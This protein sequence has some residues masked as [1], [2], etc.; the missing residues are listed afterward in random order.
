MFSPGY[1]YLP[2]SPV[3]I[4]TRD[5]DNQTREGEGEKFQ[6]SKTFFSSL[7][8]Q[9]SRM[10]LVNGRKAVFQHLR[11]AAITNGGY[12]EEPFNGR[13]LKE[14]KD[15]FGTD[16]GARYLAAVDRYLGGVFGGLGDTGK[17]RI[18]HSSHHVLIVSA[19]YGLLK[20]FEP[21]Q[22]CNY[23]QGDTPAAYTLWNRD[24][25][26]T[27]LLA[28]YIRTYEIRRIFDFTAF[29][30]PFLHG[31]FRWERI[32]NLPRIEVLH[33]GHRWGRGGDA[34][35]FFGIFLRDTLLPA[36]PTE[37]LDLDPET[38]YDDIIFRRELQQDDEF[39]KLL[40]R[41]ESAG[42]EFK[43]RALWSL[44]PL[45]PQT[46]RI[47]SPE[48]IR[49]GTDASTF[50]LA[51][52]IAGFLN[53]EGGDLIIGLPESGEDRAEDPGNGIEADY[54]YLD[55]KGV[56]GYQAMLADSVIRKY[57]DNDFFTRHNTFLSIRFRETGGKTLCWIH[58]KK[59]D[60]P[61]FL[62]AGNEVLFFVRTVTQTREIRKMNELYR[63]TSQHF[64]R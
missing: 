6:E 39:S 36:R 12:E 28:D 59:S 55:N 38:W 56:G 23:P 41:G 53:T 17:K 21:I 61:V 58:I 63:Y 16:T 37:L 10:S 43:S 14:G 18:A 62:D 9:D 19:A 57:F 32:T 46:A 30:L 2:K 15:F 7:T 44:D 48:Y 11:N 60:R 52:T 25:R 5:S 4:L 64:N 24:D 47:P 8:G 54:R 1:P 35:P 50:I 31:I 22:Y 20:P 13:N 29:S 49:Y 51:K 27:G 34:L 40:A 45:D 42:T 26:I 3:L 33:A